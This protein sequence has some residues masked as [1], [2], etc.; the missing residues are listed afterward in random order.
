MRLHVLSLPWTMTNGQHPT[1]A[2]TAKVEKFARMMHQRGHHVVIYSGEDNTAPCTEHVTAV[3]RDEQGDLLGTTDAPWDPA[4]PLWQ[5]F[6]NRAAREVRARVHEH[7]LLLLI[8]SAQW[9]VAE[10][11]P[12]VQA[13]EFG[14]GYA[15]TRAPFRVFES[16]AWMHTIYGAQMGHNADGREYDTVIPNY[17]D[18]ADFGPVCPPDD[19]PYFLFIGRGIGRKRPQIAADVAR[20]LG[21]HLVLAGHDLGGFPDYG[22]R[23]GPVDREARRRLMAGAAAVFVPTLY[24]GPFEG[25]AVEALLSGAPVI[26]SDFGAFTETVGW[27]DGWRC[28]TM[29][30]YVAAGRSALHEAGASGPTS[31]LHRRQ[32]AVS[33]FSLDAVAP[34]YERYLERVLRLH[35]GGWESLEYPPVPGH[36]APVLTE[37]WRGGPK[38]TVTYGSA[39]VGTTGPTG[40]MRPPSPPWLPART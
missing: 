28:S 3:T 30:D 33:R 12:H 13:V 35:T 31:R 21:V 36:Q 25:V 8:T 27:G 22:E 37:E 11:V 5:A 40:D 34:L 39:I 4:H 32:C 23:V 9:P 7:D 24:V 2:Y 16:Y 18:P 20:Y 1:C 19:P 14:V 10:A 26:C 6:N 38:P 29:A 17:F 15:G